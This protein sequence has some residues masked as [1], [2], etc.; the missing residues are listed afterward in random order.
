VS[1]TIDN[2]LG[3][4]VNYT[5]DY[6]HRLTGATATNSSWGEAYSYD[7]F[8]NLTGKTPTVGTAPPF[9]GS[10]GSNAA[11]G[12]LPAN[13]DVENRLTASNPTNSADHYTYGYDPWGR[14]VEAGLQ[15]L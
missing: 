10:V 11:G 3:E 4:T 1:Q 12:S 15:Q 8:G 2:S 6:L 7:G 5:Y 13:F 9:L 14:R